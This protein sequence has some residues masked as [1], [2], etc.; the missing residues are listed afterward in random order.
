MSNLSSLETITIGDDSFDKVTSLSFSHLTSLQ[1][2]TIG[3]GSFE[4]VQTLKITDMNRLKTIEIGRNSFTGVKKRDWDNNLS[5]ALK[6]ANNASKSFHI[7]NCE[8]LESIQ[9][10]KWSFS[11]FAGIIEL[12]NLPHLQSLNIGT[13]DTQ[14]HFSSNFFWGSFVIR[15]IDMVLSMY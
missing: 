9:I 5:D 10:D 12:K 1:S 11:D 14:S 3:D 2:I 6:K 15:G 13:I 4:S 8:S 7:L